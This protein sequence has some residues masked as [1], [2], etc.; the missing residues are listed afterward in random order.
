MKK[1]LFLLFV[2]VAFVQ[3]S[4]LKKVSFEEYLTKFD[5]KERSDMKIKTPEMLV[6]IEEGKAILLDIRFR[7]EFEVWHMNFAKNIPLNELPNRL[8][9]LP[10]DKLIITACPHYDRSSMVRIYLKLNGYDTRYLSDG[11][12]KTA[13][14]LRGDNAKEFLDEYKAIKKAK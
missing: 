8:N 1:T 11:L 2:M 10:K 7:E 12:L 3:A 5:Y 13:D 14:F 6:L 4:E 9:E